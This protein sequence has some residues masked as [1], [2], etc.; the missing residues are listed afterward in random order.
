M[1]YCVGAFLVF[2]P[3]CRMREMVRTRTF[4]MTKTLLV[5]GAAGFIG[6]TFA[7][8]SIAR[9]EKVVIL[10]ALTYA[11]RRENIPT[12]PNCRFITG[13][14]CDKETVS[15]IFLENK[16]DYVVNF[17]AESHVDNSIKSS[18]IFINTN[19]NGT[20]NMLE[21]SREYWSNL[22]GTHKE[23]FRYL[24]ISTDE[25]YGSLEIDD[26]RKFNE[27]T[28]YDPSSP[29]SASKAASD[30]LVKAWHITYGLPTIIT[31]CSNNYGQRQFTEK[32]IPRMITN[33]ISGKELPI[34]G[35]GKNIRDWI[36]VE[37]HCSGVYLA[38]TKGIPGQTYCLGGNAEKNNIEVVET[39]C[40]VLDELKP[41]S[42]GKSYKEQII[43]VTDRPGHDRRYAIDDSKAVAQLGFIRQYDF[44]TGI[45]QTINWYLGKI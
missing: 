2:S 6:S 18:G 35:D 39:I 29:Y 13:N 12:H 34:Y 27:N 17:A 30:H 19:I 11:G 14:I 41:R 36:H 15:R 9:G 45:R 7:E 23:N 8:Q 26:G 43:F 42:D 16:I 33:A 24:Q 21:C 20:H 40:T 31:N 10:D 32:L 4:K 37:D 5:T 3:I 1:L 28:P 44:E 22:T 38:L 25:V